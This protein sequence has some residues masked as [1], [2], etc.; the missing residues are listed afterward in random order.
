MADDIS[1]IFGQSSGAVGSAPS[2]TP[3]AA[4]LGVQTGSTPPSPQQLTANPLPLPGTGGNTDLDMAAAK[5]TL[6]SAVKAKTDTINAQANQGRM[7]AIQGQADTILQQLPAAEM[8]KAKTDAEA[9]TQ[10]V[11]AAQAF[12]DQ[13]KPVLEAMKKK[14]PIPDDAPPDYQPQ[15]PLEKFGSL[16]SMLGIFASAFTRTPIVNA[17]NSSAAAMKAANEGNEEA[18]QRNYEK[19]K[20]H[21]ALGIKRAQE[22]REQLKDIL[23]LSKTDFSLATAQ[24]QALAASKGWKAVG[25]TTQANDLEGLGKLYES[26]GKA[27]NGLEDQ[28][29]FLDLQHKQAIVA[30][31]ERKAEDAKSGGLTPEGR[32]DAA[33]QYAITGAMPPMGMGG[34]KDRESIMNEAA[35]IRRDAGITVEDQISGRAGLKADTKSL[36]KIQPQMDSVEAFEGTAKSNMQNALRLANK[37]AGTSGGS[38]VNRWIQAGRKAT[39]DPDVAA[40]NAALY[41]AST[42]YAKV[43]SG[44]VNNQSLTDSA[45]A[46]AENKVINAADSPEAIKKVYD[47][48]MVPDMNNRR[49]SLEDQVKDIKGRM[50]S[51]GGKLDTSA[52]RAAAPNGPPQGVDPDDWAYLTPEEQAKF[53]GQ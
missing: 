31:D 33:M 3:L 52:Q 4:Q 9:K 5:A 19:W 23:D 35:K 37:G 30:A 16:S 15:S 1:S 50:G 28:M 44:A 10:E 26:L 24:A 47:E 45:R 22:E 29:K 34:S 21:A 32:Q 39:G 51:W 17:L 18:Y 25:L 38:V 20:D 40:F 53:G 11:Q 48:V 46:E 27:T 36:E 14:A 43:M 6:D 12:R 13:I 41:T 42:E 49:K 2:P 7:R 8:E